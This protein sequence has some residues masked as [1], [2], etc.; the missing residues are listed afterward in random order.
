MAGW[1]R[2]EGLVSD[3]DP[4]VAAQENAGNPH[5][6]PTAGQS[7]KIGEGE[8]VLLDLWGK[9]TQSGSVYADITWVGFTGTRIPDEM[10]RAFSAVCA[11]RD[12]ALELVRDA[13]RHRRELRGWQV[14]RAARDVLLQAGYGN[15]ILHRT[16]HSLGTEVHGNGVHMDDFES[17]DDRRLLPGSGF[18]VEPGLYFEAFGVRTEVNVFLGEGGAEVTGPAQAEIAAL[19]SS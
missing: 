4:V 18:T 7:R 19:G 8:L 11:A 15:H 16:G 13:A 14:D 6:M 10:A 1:F 17:H 5:Y 12:G 9:L 2:E 3:S